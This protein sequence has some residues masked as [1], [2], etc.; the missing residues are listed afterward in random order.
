MDFAAPFNLEF[1]ARGRPFSPAGHSPHFRAGEKEEAWKRG[2]GSCSSGH[3]LRTSNG[4]VSV[5]GLS[6]FP[7][8]L[9]EKRKRRG[10]R[11]TSSLCTVWGGVGQNRSMGKG[12]L[13]WKKRGVCRKEEGGGG[14]NGWGWWAGKEARRST[15]SRSSHY[16]KWMEEGE[17][18]GERKKGQF[19]GWRGS[20][21]PALTPPPA[22]LPPSC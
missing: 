16:C 14:G 5:G 15:R 12:S 21:I 9:K 19:A 11:E 20:S 7:S 13:E 3:P 4:G 17:R 22:L 8:N 10:R 18:K 1:L 2:R 6:A